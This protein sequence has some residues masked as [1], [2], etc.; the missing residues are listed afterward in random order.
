MLS[1]NAVCPINYCYAVMLCGILWF[2]NVLLISNCLFLCFYIL[3]VKQSQGSSLNGVFTNLLRNM[4]LMLFLQNLR[5][6]L[7]LNW[8]EL[9]SLLFDKVL[10]QTSTVLIYNSYKKLVRPKLP[11]LSL[12]CLNGYSCYF[13][14]VLVF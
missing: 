5:N 2:A 14:L 13:F 9:G 6:A 4:Y 7:M 11:T 8:L 3:L 1:H 10:I 12:K